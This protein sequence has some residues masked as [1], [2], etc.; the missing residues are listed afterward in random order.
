M[1]EQKHAVLLDDDVDDDDDDDDDDFYYDYDYDVDSQFFACLSF[2][3]KFHQN[4]S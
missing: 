3:F 4:S 2:V 1:S